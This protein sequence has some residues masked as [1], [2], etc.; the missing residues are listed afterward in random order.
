MCI[1]PRKNRVSHRYPLHATLPPYPSHETEFLCQSLDTLFYRANFP[2]A[3]VLPE[4][5]TVRGAETL[6]WLRDYIQ[7]DVDLVKLYGRWAERDPV[8][9]KL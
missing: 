9:A 1:V 4:T 8:F 6:E 7:L 5:V 2:D 3:S